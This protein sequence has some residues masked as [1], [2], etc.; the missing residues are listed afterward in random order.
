MCATV[1]GGVIAN[2]GTAY[3]IPLGG[4][5]VA[6][7]AKGGSGAMATGG[8]R[9]GG[10]AGMGTLYGLPMAGAGVGGQATAVEP[11]LPAASPATG[12]NPGARMWKAFPEPAGREEV[13]LRTL[14]A[15]R[16][17][18]E[19]GRAR[20]RS[21][22][23]RVAP[24]RCLPGAPTDPDLPNSGIRLVRSRIR[25]AQVYRVHDSRS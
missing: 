23:G 22:R 8:V 1:P 5:G 21:S 14:P 20:E 2:G 9:T 12:L 17:P 15:R 11:R 10:T 25:Y 19:T 16:V 24:S 7:Q 18:P 3:G 4:N 6:G 13:V